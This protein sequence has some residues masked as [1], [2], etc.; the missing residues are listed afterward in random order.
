MGVITV[1]NFQSIVVHYHF[2]SLSLLREKVTISHVE[3]N[4]IEFHT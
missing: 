4:T 2:Y 3:P 1:F